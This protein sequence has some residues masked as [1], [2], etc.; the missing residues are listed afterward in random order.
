[1]LKKQFQQNLQVIEDDDC[2]RV[3][4][5]FDRL[6]CEFEMKTTE[7]VRSWGTLPNL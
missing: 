6:K 1:M 5:L 7:K 2:W 3:P 4:K